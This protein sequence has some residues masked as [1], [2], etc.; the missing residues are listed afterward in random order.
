MF[1]VFCFFFLLRRYHYTSHLVH[2]NKKI[3]N[4]FKMLI[5]KHINPNSN[6]NSVFNNMDRTSL[7]FLIISSLHERILFVARMRRGHN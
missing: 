7:F 3:T 5:N 6:R 2:N 1:L 4:M